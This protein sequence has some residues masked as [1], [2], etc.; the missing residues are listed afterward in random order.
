MMYKTTENL[1]K[2]IELVN[3]DSVMKIGLPSQ[4][5]L[6]QYT[7]YKALVDEINKEI[8]LEEGSLE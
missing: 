2:E 5:Y 7:N 1:H 4:G 6:R 8:E 3:M